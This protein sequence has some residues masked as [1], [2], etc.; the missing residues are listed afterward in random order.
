MLLFYRRVIYIFYTKQTNVWTTFVP[1]MEIVSLSE[2]ESSHV[3]VV[4]IFTARD[5]KRV[6]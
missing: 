4:K 3:N 2:M 6:K 5:V 1:T